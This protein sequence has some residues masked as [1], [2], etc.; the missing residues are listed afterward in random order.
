MVD[1]LYREGTTSVGVKDTS[2]LLKFL[3]RKRF[4]FVLSAVVLMI[5]V[6]GSLVWLLSL[7]SPTPNLAHASDASLPNNITANGPYSVRGN[8]IIDAGGN[9][10]IFHGIGRDGLEFNCSGDNALDQQHLA[11]M[12]S[13][14]NTTNPAAGTYW[15]ANTI[16]LPL[17]EGFWL[18]GAPGYPCSAGQ[19]QALVKKIV[20]DVTAL[21]LNV[22]LDLQWVDAGGQAGQGGAPAAMPDDDSVTF[23]QQV[24]G[25][26]KGYN[27]VLFELFNE[28]HQPQAYSGSPN[29]WQCW[30]SGCDISKDNG[31]ADDCHCTKMLS[32]HAV[33]MQTLVD[34]VRDTAGA[35]NLVLV[36][37]L[38]WG[39]DLSQL[40]NHQITGSNV[41]YDTHP[42]PYAGKLPVDWD[43]SFGNLTDTYPIISAESGQYDCKSD[44]M[45]QLLNYFDNHRM[46]W[47]AWAWIVPSGNPPPCGYP[48]LITDN[49]GTP[50]SWSGQYVYQ[51]M[52]SYAPYDGPLS[53]T[54]YFAEGRVASNFTEVLS[55]INPDPVNDCA[56][57]IKY[58][59]D[60]GRTINKNNVVV[61]HNSRI[62]EGV[63]ADLGAQNVQQGVSVAAIVSVDTATCGGIVAERP[64]Y[65]SFQG[66][67]SNSDI[68]GATRLNNNFYF[69]DVPTGSGYVSFLSILNPPGNP[70]ADVTATYYLGSKVVGSQSVTVQAGQRGTI[71]PNGRGLPTHVAAVVTSSQA[72]M[73]ERPLYLKGIAAG[74]AQRVTG[75]S[76][77][78]G[79]QALTN[80]WLFAEGYTGKGFQ[81]YL[82]IANLDRA[83]TAAKVTIKLQF[84][85]GT[86]SSYAVTVKPFDQLLWDVNRIAPN[87]DVSVEVTSQGASV[88]VQRQMYFHY[89]GTTQGGNDVIG[90]PGPATS[91]NA[92][93]YVFAE[94]FAPSGYDEWLT[95]QNPTAN[96]EGVMLYLVNGHGKG[97]TP[98]GITLPA[99]SRQT[100]DISSLVRQKMYQSGEST[101]GYAISMLVQGLPGTVFVAERPFYVNLNRG[102]TQGGSDVIGF[103]G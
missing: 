49:T 68:M 28:P 69:A 8:R 75:G 83:D 93:Y 66:V 4:L 52:Q 44:Y 15:G 99:H 7:V 58:L 54:W 18:H 96:D 35:S 2:M 61:P 14:I 77:M 22:I 11:F 102:V 32:Y 64:M 31:Y 98:G 17:S 91:S 48:Q 82:A 100:I 89:K 10:Y 56:V 73:V 37:G 88:V 71:S 9:E 13:A 76:S 46:S 62:T 80:D 38:N 45:N 97:Y 81:E 60:N 78:M 27:N 36:G 95:L 50:T 21:K 5:V 85:N 23:W 47:I 40:P 19:Y 20:D 70:A 12:G 87:R 34:A 53:N 42:Y 29:M 101:A 79:A 30:F 86:T 55:L 6:G 41:V 74:N 90:L 51:H 43:N 1:M 92:S 103:N 84:S 57:T 63:N 16:R 24:A 65:Y 94:G 67:N 59:L 39:Y 25:R 26:F 3:K 72:I 33:G